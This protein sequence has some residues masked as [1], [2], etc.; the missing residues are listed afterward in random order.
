LN[1]D[2]SIFISQP[3]SYVFVYSLNIYWIPTN[4]PGTIVGHGFLPQY[5]KIGAT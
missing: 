2:G 1:W 5:F 3:L 4:E